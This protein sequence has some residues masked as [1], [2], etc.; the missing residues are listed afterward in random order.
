MV[1]ILALLLSSCGNDRHWDVGADDNICGQDPCYEG[2]FEPPWL[3]AYDT[4][5]AFYDSR[6]YK[7]TCDNKVLETENVLTFSDASSDEVKV[8]YAQMTETAFS[9]LKIL[10][11]ISSSAE[12]GIVDRDTKM[13]IYSNRYQNHRQNSLL[14]GFIL[15]AIDSAFWEDRA[16]I[17]P[18]FIPWF[19]REV[20]HETMH[21]IQYYFGA[22]YSRVYPWYTEGIA[23]HVSGGAH[24][25]ITCWEEVEEWRQA[26]DHINPI[27]IQVYD[28]YPVPDSRIGEFYPLFGLAVRYLMDEKGRGKTPLD[29]KHM[30]LDSGSGTPFGEAFELH[31]G[32][33][34]E[35]YEAHFWEWMEVFLPPNCD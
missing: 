6:G 11:D 31:M 12:L 24:P 20:K 33:T 27:S 19:R 5:L 14:Y 34:V 25:P 7:L 26:E 28:D 16:A 23:E 35:V 9:E 2:P 13:T 18:D 30:F 8:Q 15:Y 17:D 32:L 22:T 21:V 3:S 1:L 10:F 4:G 29:V